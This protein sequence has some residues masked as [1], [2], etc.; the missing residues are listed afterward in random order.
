MTSKSHRLFAAV[1]I[2][3][4]VSVAFT[5]HG[6]P[7]EDPRQ[8]HD[9]KHGHKQAQPYASPSR[10][11]QPAAQQQRNAHVAPP[12]DFAPV[13]QAFQ[14]RRAQIGRGPDLPPGVH[15]RQGHPLPH[16]Y[17]KR[18]D[19]HALHG[20]PHYQG[21]EWRRV[22]SDVVLIALSSGLVSA[23]LQGVLN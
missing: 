6:A 8:S 18:L 12:K 9:Q 4:L 10:Q 22:G 1:S 21:Y 20:L 19:A 5:A 13:H 17:G 3:L 15:I 23:I 11:A 2:A 16:G 7:G 14:Q